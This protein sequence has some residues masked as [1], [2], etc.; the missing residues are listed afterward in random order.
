M[1]PSPPATVEAIP[2]QANAIN[3]SSTCLAIAFQVACKAPAPMTIATINGVRCA[4]VVTYAFCLFVRAI[5][6]SSYRDRHRAAQPADA[7]DAQTTTADPVH[8]PSPRDP[9]KLLGS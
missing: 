2:I 7:R 1:S 4:W 6:A 3:R 8:E 5:A 9:R